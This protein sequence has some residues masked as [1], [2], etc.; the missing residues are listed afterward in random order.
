[1]ITLTQ[2]QIQEN[3]INKLIDLVL[4]LEKKD[5]LTT[6]RFS[7]LIILLTK[8]LTQLL[9]IEIDEQFELVELD[10]TGIKTAIEEK[11]EE[12]KEETKILKNEYKLNYDGFTTINKELN[13]RIDYS[14]T[15]G[16]EHV[17]IRRYF[18]DTLKF[19]SEYKY[20][21]FLYK[22]SLK[23]YNSLKEMKGK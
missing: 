6:V 3:K 22:N 18:A 14:F 1:M 7:K 13:N 17:I 8:K 21:G 23:T 16:Y 20:Q 10:E 12:K 4:E 5:K 11:K 2:R 9:C 15:D 19:I